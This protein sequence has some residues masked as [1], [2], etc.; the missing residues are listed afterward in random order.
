MTKRPNPGCGE[1]MSATLSC[2]RE[3]GHPGVHESYRDG[4]TIT[5]PNDRGWQ[6]SWGEDE[7]GTYWFLANGRAADPDKYDSRESAEAACEI[8][9][10]RGMTPGPP[11][12]S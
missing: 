2:K 5:A 10:R 6:V 7:D 1:A 12:W 8:A 9:N 11:W 4:K 3:P